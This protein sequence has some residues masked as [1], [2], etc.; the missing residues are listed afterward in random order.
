MW[1]AATRSP[2]AMSPLP[3]RFKSKSLS[4]IAKPQSREIYVELLFQ[5]WG[6][7]GACKGRMWGKG[8]QALKIVCHPRHRRHH[9][10]YACLQEL[11]GTHRPEL[12]IR[13]EAL[14]LLPTKTEPPPRFPVSAK[15]SLRPPPRAHSGRGRGSGR[16]RNATNTH[17]RQSTTLSERPSIFN[18]LDPRENNSHGEGGGRGV[19]GREKESIL[20]AHHNL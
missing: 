18:L 6:V 9:D 2:Q 1:V 16:P 19:G 8:C 17:T 12:C 7:G 3:C 4:F 20:G 14:H 15:R 5:C 11:F 10:V 13:P